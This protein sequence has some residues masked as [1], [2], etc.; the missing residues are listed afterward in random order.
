M[1]IDKLEFRNG[2][3]ISDDISDRL[4]DIFDK[5]K[6]GSIDYKEFIDT[7]E[8]M[9]GGTEEEKIKFAFELHDLDNN[10]YIDRG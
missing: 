7:I 3:D 5:D 10:G 8:S 4:F 9:I 2:L 1:L 6:N